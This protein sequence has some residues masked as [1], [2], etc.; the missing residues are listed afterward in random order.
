[1]SNIKIEIHF[2][3]VGTHFPEGFRFPLT[4]TPFYPDTYRECGYTAKIVDYNRLVATSPY[5]DTREFVVSYSMDGND[6]RKLMA[7]GCDANICFWKAAE[8]VAVAKLNN[9]V[10]H[11]NRH[12]W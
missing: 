5:G 7:R 4:C 1:M 9:I 8:R 3:E 6:D 11:I 12:H 2:T 10:R